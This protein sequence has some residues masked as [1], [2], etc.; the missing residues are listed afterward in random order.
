MSIELSLRCLFIQG[1]FELVINKVMKE[2]TC[3]NMKMEAYYAEVQKVDDKFDDI[4]L[5]H[6]LRWDNEEA[7]SLVRLASFQKPPPSRVFLDVLD[8]P[9][10]HLGEGKAPALAG[11]TSTSTCA[12]KGAPSPQECMLVVTTR[13]QCGTK[14]LAS[15]YRGPNTRVPNEVELITI[16]H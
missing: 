16:E 10:I 4:E 5:H 8:T 13:S 1:D 12:T 6:V 14:P 3:H 11:A 9:S 15:I 7:D 2:S